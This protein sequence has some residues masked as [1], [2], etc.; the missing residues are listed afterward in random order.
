MTPDQKLREV[1]EKI[2]TLRSA[3]KVSRRS[4]GS[5]RPLRSVQRLLEN[6]YQDLLSWRETDEESEWSFKKAAA[7]Q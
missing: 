5:N 2:D 1:E 4:D 3:V 6:M 7:P